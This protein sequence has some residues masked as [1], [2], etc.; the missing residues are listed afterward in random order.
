MHTVFLEAKTHVFRSANSR[1]FIKPVALWQSIK[2]IPHT[3][4]V[5]VRED[6][7]TDV[8]LVDGW[9]QRAR[10]TVAVA[11]QTELTWY[12]LFLMLHPQ[13]CDLLE[14]DGWR[15][16]NSVSSAIRL[17]GRVSVG[18]R[19]N[20]HNHRPIRHGGPWIRNNSGKDM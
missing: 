18:P 5:L 7:C 19:P 20:A 3:Y 14:V 4:S 10:T 15:V 13:S 12:R 6:D 17:M 2:L 1:F 16:D 9:I 8:R 11:V